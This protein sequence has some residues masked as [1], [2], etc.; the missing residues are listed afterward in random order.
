MTTIQD[1]DKTTLADFMMLRV[2]PATLLLVVL[3]VALAAFGL[4]TAASI[5]LAVCF[6]L[7]IVIACGVVIDLIPVVVGR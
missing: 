6:V 4:Q 3:A 1:A 2:T 5:I 7:A